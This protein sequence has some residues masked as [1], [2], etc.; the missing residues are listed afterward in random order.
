[1]AD[2][3]RETIIAAALT[4]LAEITV[5]NGYQYTM[6]TPKRAQRAIDVRDFPVSVLFPGT[7]ENTRGYGKDNL[8]F[9]LRVESHRVIA[10][11]ENASRIQEK[12]LGDL[13][14]NLTNPADV[15]ST[16]TDDIAYTEGGPAEQP[17][18]E[19]TTTAVYVLILVKYKT[20]IGNP[21]T[22]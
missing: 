11:S 8:E 3:I 16:L 1:M 2:T 5:A 7:E 12:M 20:K 19:D 10:A 13:R 4:Q 14:L 21:Y 18:A 9:T 15:W 6:I 17:E 22:Q